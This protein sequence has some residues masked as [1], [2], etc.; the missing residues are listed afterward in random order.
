VGFLFGGENENKRRN[1]QLLVYYAC[2]LCI[3]S[4]VQWIACR[5]YIIFSL[6]LF[7]V[8]FMFKTSIRGRS[9]KS[10]AQFAAELTEEMQMK[11]TITITASDGK[12]FISGPLKNGEKM[13][14]KRKRDW[15]VKKEA[16]D[17]EKG[18]IGIGELAKLCI[19]KLK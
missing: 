8:L 2:G 10:P 7:S 18:L 1:K 11:L 13:K 9:M 12:E 14:E 4:N 16:I 19:R 3:N 17:H 15:K 6:N 5:G